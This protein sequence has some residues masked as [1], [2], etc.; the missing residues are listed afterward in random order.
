MAGPPMRSAMEL[1]LMRGTIMSKGDYDKGRGLL[2]L[3]EN[4]GSLQVGF[5]FFLY[6]E[7]SS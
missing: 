1:L 5:A 3:R 7:E 4:T 2:E 6:L